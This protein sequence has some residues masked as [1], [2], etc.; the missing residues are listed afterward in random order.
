MAFA[1]SAAEGAGRIKNAH[2]QGHMQS[3]E[4]VFSWLT[5]QQSYIY[6]DPSDL[7]SVVTPSH[8]VN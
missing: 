6:S 1:P 2:L 3:P 7:E 8:L 5:A 4:K